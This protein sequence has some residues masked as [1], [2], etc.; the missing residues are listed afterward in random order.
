MSTSL[1]L[2]AI[3][4][5]LTA[6]MDTED[7]VSDEQRLEFLNDLAEANQQA[8][9]KR[10]N[11]IRFLRH[12]DL[13]QESITAEQE[14]LSKLK[15]VYANTQERVEKHVAGVI[16]RF[17]P[18]PKRGPKKLEGSIGVLSLRKNPDHVEILNPEAVPIG[19]RDVS[20]KMPAVV[21]AHLLDENPDL[22]A[23]VKSCR[24]E[25]RKSEVSEAIKAGAEIPGVDLVYGLNRLCVK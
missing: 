11:V 21:W 17:A 7:L 19:Y 3:E 1:T 24:S 22:E 5:Q 4:D 16:E 2:Y 25:V 23:N 13:Q 6:L 12:L 18:E 15:A 9:V 20:L 14:R 8:V 10:D